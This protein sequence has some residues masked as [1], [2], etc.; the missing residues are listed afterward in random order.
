LWDCSLHGNIAQKLA[1]GEVFHSGA[2]TDVAFGVSSSPASP[3]LEKS[4]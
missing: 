4:V 1:E 2:A 3:S